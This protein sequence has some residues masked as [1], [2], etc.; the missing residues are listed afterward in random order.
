MYR[1]TEK[2]RR[3]ICMSLHKICCLMRQLDSLDHLRDHM[4]IHLA[5]LAELVRAN[6]SGSDQSASYEGQLAATGRV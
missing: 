5:K 4:R 6:H 1:S 2:T 3:C